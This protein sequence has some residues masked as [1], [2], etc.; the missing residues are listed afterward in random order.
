MPRLPLQ[1]SPIETYLPTV[2]QRN[3]T[4]NSVVTG[5]N[6]LFDSKG[7]K[8]GFSSRVLTPFPFSDPAHV[9]GIIVQDRTI[10]FTGDAILA[11]RS[12]V[13]FNWELLYNFQSPISASAVGAWH[14]VF[15]EGQLYLSHRSRGLFTSPIT[16]GTEQLSLRP[17]TDTEVPGLIAGIRGMAVVR[18]RPIIVN[19]DTIQWGAVGD[20]ED[21]TP[22]LGG[23][24]FQL[25][26]SFAQGDFL[27]LSSFQDGFVVWTE[28]GPIVGEYI[29][30]EEVWEFY[31]LTTQ[32][33]PISV[34]ATVRLESG[35]I[36]FLTRHG[37]MQATAQ[38]V[39]PY[40]AEFNAFFLDYMEGRRG[41]LSR[42]QFWRLDYNPKRETL[43]LSE[44]SDGVTYWRTFVFNPTRDKWGLFSEKHYGFLSLTPDTFGYVAVDGTPHYFVDSFSRE[45]EPSNEL[46]YN[47]H[48][49]RH[50]KAMRIPSSS[51]VSRAYVT[52][53][54]APMDP[55]DPPSVGWYSGPGQTPKG[56]DLNGLDSW[57]E[58]GM[59]RPG[60]IQGLTS[61]SF[62]IQEA[63]VSSVPGV[64]N[65]PVDF[66]SKHHKNL[67][68]ATY[69]DWHSA[70]VVVDGDLTEDYNTSEL[71]D[72]DLLQQPFN[73]HEDYITM[74]YPDVTFED[75]GEEDWNEDAASEDWGGK[76]SGLIPID[77]NFQWLASA[78]G[79]TFDI[80]EPSMARFDLT[81][82]L[83][84]GISA[85][86]FHR[87][88]FEALEAGQY[89]H[90]SYFAVAIQYEGKLG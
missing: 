47:R 43:Y 64:P 17:L 88:R 60:E 10:V 50:Q 23:A 5:R 35:T 21:L 46:G 70:G 27:A 12:T 22:A 85:G 38:S 41:N 87:F 48:Y 55:L 53:P 28:G 84:T 33:K 7:P 57:I 79:I 45:G 89:Y 67:F 73:Q 44:S 37:L 19:N 71:E 83:W 2:D 78:D 65:F 29:G 74:N 77:Y 90:V 14:A 42:T 36:I 20:F 13:P 51:A 49:P 69:E 80:Y 4:R 32:L 40:S 39:E 31:P 76:A 26:R 72:Q 54:E 30:G 9:Q 75:D 66:K 8:S 58:I 3:S 61:E 34:R 6:F 59:V 68:Y 81:A 25:I 86:A 82:Q 62:E 16:V 11:W 63:V 15:L 1:L 56:G 24:G 18:S 52:N